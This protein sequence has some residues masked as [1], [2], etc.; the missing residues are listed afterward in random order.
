MS[1]FK[2]I[3]VVADKAERAQTAL[4]ELMSAYELIPVESKADAETVD[5][6][7]V[8][9][10]DGFM[11]HILHDYMECNVPIYGMNC[12]TVGFLMNEYRCDDLQ[13]LLEQAGKTVIHPLKMTAKTTG[14]RVVESLA[15]NEVSLLRKSAQAARIK[16]II[17]GTTQM[18]ELVAD[19]VLVATPAGSSA[20]NLSAGGPILPLKSNLLALTPISI[21]RPRR[22]HG[23]LLSHKAHIRFELLNPAKRPV[24]AVADFNEVDDVASVDICED[25]DRAITLLFDKGHS[26]EERILSEQFSV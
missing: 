2:R 11:L 16:V 12:G 10:G 8:L 21:F 23:A 5:V 14:D 15:I 18:E 17:D 25:R 7:V 6:I 4:E 13:E 9:G 20:Y 22:W 1:E 26:L 19:G 3:G 24:N